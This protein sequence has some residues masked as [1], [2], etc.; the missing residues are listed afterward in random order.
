MGI[1]VKTP[2]SSEKRHSTRHG[3]AQIMHRLLLAP[4]MDCGAG[5]ETLTAWKDSPGATR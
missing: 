4:Q 1:D 5:P 2:D 3:V